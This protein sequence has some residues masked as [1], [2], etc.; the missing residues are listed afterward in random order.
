MSQWERERE[1]F[2]GE[3]ANHYWRPLHLSHLLRSSRL[4]LLLLLRPFIP[5]VILL[6]K[7]H[8]RDTLE[9]MDFKAFVLSTPLTPC[10]QT[11][12]G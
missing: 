12:P 5:D 6:T 2:L 4:L 1:V 10:H 3:V 9:Q 11:H 8:M 7:D